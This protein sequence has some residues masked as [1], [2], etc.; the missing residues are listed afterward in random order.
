MRAKIANADECSRKFSVLYQFGRWLYAT[1]GAISCDTRGL[2]GEKF[3]VFSL[4]IYI[5]YTCRVRALAVCLCEMC[6]NTW[7]T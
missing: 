1:F 5:V 4:N 2:S 3:P 6:K 7:S